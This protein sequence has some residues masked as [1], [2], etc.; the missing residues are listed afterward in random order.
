MADL[1]CL[2]QEVHITQL[3]VDQISSCIHDANFLQNNLTKYFNEE[4]KKRNN[5]KQD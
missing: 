5:D 4:A 3:F 2:K 1:D